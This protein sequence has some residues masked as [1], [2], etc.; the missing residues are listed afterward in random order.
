MRERERNL[1]REVVAAWF[2]VNNEE[3]D[4]DDPPPDCDF[5]E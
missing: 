4:E 3:D 1:E 2:R 5:W